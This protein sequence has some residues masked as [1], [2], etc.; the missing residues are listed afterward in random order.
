MARR[1]RRPREQ[2]S[3]C[4]ILVVMVFALTAWLCY[5]LLTRPDCP[6]HVT[7]DHGDGG[8]ERIILEEDE[9]R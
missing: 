7:V 1:R 2:G 5:L 6:I 3:G 9:F 8:A 4:G